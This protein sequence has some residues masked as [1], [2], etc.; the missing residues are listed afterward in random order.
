VLVKHP[1]TETVLAALK[2]TAPPDRVTPDP[3]T[4]VGVTKDNPGIGAARYDHVLVPVLII[5][6]KSLVARALIVPEIVTPPVAVTVQAPAPR[7]RMLI[8]VPVG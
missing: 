8:R 7:F 6:A 2:L 5:D 3:A 4:D 1:F